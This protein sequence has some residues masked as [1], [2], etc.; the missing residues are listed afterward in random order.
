MQK[1]KIALLTESRYIDPNPSDA[2]KKEVLKEDELLAAALAQY[3][4]EA[5]RVNW[6]DPHYDWSSVDY[7]V[8]RS[9]WDYFYRFSD[10][11]SWIDRVADS[12]KTINPMEL[13]RWNM[14]KHY[15]QDLADREVRIVPTRYVEAGEQT[16]LKAVFAEGSYSRAI[17]KPAVSGTARH[18]YLIDRGNV[19]A[20]EEVFK[21]LIS[22][23][24]MLVQ[25]FLKNIAERG[26]VSFVVFDGKFSHAVLKKAKAGDFRVQ[27]DFGGTVEQYQASKREVEFAE[28]A[29]A[30]CELQPVYARVDVAWDDQGEMS[31]VE[32]EL[33]EPDMWLRQNEGSAERFAAAIAAHLKLTQ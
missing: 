1:T 15:L 12:I 8:F 29:V 32:L 20:H 4:C 33:I 5:E 24:C 2:Y 25:P 22:E 3:N 31:L 30:V 6:A 9:T 16:T 17:I 10:F 27:S 11:L 14:D 13:V 23:E 26:E 19:D 18:T 7:A 28:H 21:K